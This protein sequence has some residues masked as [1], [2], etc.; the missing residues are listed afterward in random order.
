MAQI[1]VEMTGV[2]AT[3]SKLE[4]EYKDFLGRTAVALRQELQKHTPI[5][6]GNARN[7]WKE[8]VK[9]DSVEVVNNVPY[10]ERLENNH[11][12]QTKGRGIV[13]PALSSFNRR[14]V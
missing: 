2:S 13:K 5:D 6:K 4:K 8:S 10:I 11:S 14:K 1:K 9:S 7:N 12:K 3:L